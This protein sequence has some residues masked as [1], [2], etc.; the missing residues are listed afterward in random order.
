M[1]DP[2]PEAFFLLG[3]TASGKTSLSLELAGALDAELFCLD[4]MQLYQG[5]PVA[6]A[7][8][9]SE[10]RSRVPHHLF[11]VLS[12]DQ[13][14]DAGAF[15]KLAVA[16][17]PEVTGRGKKILFV[18]GTV[19]Y[20]KALVE[21]LADLPARDPE[22]RRELR[23]SWDQDQ[24]ET[25]RAELLRVDP[26]RFEALGP[27]D[28]RRIERA[29]EVF[30]LTGVP[31]SE[32]HRRPLTPPL[33]SLGTVALRP[34]RSWLRERVAARQQGMLTAGLLAE[35]RALWE[36]FREAKDVPTA[37]QAIGYRHFAAHFEGTMTQDDALTK[38]LHDT[39]R[40]VRHQDTWL[41][42]L[43][44]IFSLDPSRGSLSEL[45]QAAQKAYL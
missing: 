23:A 35:M 19:L 43:S 36:R 32:L 40:L 33:R 44:G 6:S 11:E 17:L 8:P 42:K 27:R 29:L 30:R 41:R 9:T 34:D 15:V 21:G 14:C 10:E 39:N 45:T 16:K 26:E 22:L 20:Y 7:Q 12:L 5:F 24:G 37:L 2:L 4:S 18:G 31:L 13:N 28:Y 25:L 3:P 1:Q 38:M